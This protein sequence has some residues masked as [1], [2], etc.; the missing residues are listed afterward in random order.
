M[1]TKRGSRINIW[2]QHTCNLEEYNVLCE[3][4]VSQFFP[5]FLP[6]RSSE[7]SFK[8][9]FFCFAVWFC[10]LPLKRLLLIGIRETI[11]STPMLG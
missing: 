7:H 3:N 9:T 5:T 11:I 6:I 8:F 10:L 2:F 4:T 1:S